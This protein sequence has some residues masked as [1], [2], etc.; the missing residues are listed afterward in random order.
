LETMFPLKSRKGTETP[1][2]ND[3]NTREREQKSAEK[4]T[5]PPGYFFETKERGRNGEEG[6]KGQLR[7]D[8]IVVV[9]LLVRCV[10]VLSK[11]EGI[12]P[13]FAYHRPPSL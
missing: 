7:M 13:T 6:E 9:R 2:K 8:L 3:T 4:I 11:N 10:R 1:R 12:L 5:I